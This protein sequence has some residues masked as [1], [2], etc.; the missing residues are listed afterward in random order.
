MVRF[1]RGHNAGHPLVI[2]GKKTVLH[3]PT[4]RAMATS[5]PYGQHEDSKVISLRSNPTK[6]SPHH[7]EQL[8]ERLITA[9]VDVVA[10]RI[11]HLAYAPEIAGAMLQRQQANAVVAART[12]IVFDAVSRAEMALAQLKEKG[13]PNSTRNATRRWSAARWWCCARNEARS[14]WS[15]PVLC[16]DRAIA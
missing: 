3:S 5:Y 11:S 15:I 6:I 7:K 12:K 9:G 14:R 8:E 16:T 2:E 10:A 4:L 13:R 1:Q